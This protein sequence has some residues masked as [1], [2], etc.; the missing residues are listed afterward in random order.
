[1]VDGRPFAECF[2][3]VIDNALTADRVA[4]AMANETLTYRDL[5]QL[6][7]KRAG[8]LRRWSDDRGGRIALLQ[9][10]SFG[11][12][13]DILAGLCGGVSICV[14]SRS[15]SA[16]L[17]REKL[18]A[19][20]ARGILPGVSTYDLAHKIADGTD[21][22][23]APPVEDWPDAHDRIRP[24]CPN[25]QEEALIIFTSGSTSAPKGV[26]LSHKNI[27]VN[28]AAVSDVVPVD[29]DDHLLQV[30]PLHHTN[31]LLNQIVLPLSV[32]ARVTLLS[33]FEP[34]PF[35]S[36]LA[37]Y[38]PTYFT[39]V[40]T[41]LSRLLDY[42][43]PEAAVRNLRFIRSGAAPLLPDVQRRVEAHFGRE[44]VVS[45]GQ[46]ETTCTNTANPPGSRKI[47]SVGKV[48]SSRDAAILEPGSTAPV[49]PGATGEVCFRGACVAI[50]VIGE[51][52]LDP[53]AWFRTGDCG[54]FD[55]DGYLFL[56]GRLKD[57]I[58]KG[59][60]NLSPRQIEDVLLSQDD[61]S[62]AAVFGVP[63]DDLGEVPVAC[64][65]PA[66]EMPLDINRLNEG[67]AEKLS[68]AHMLRGIYEFNRLIETEIGKPDLRAM[69]DYVAGLETRRQ[70]AGLTV[71]CDDY[72]PIRYMDR[73]RHYYETLG[74]GAPYIWARNDE[75]PFALLQMPL[76]EASVAIITTAAPYRE[77][78]GD[79]GP[80]APYNAQ[81]KFYEVYG[82]ATDEIPDLRI[83]HVAIDR[84]NT[85]A[86]DPNAFFPLA[87]LY[88]AANA[89][90]IRR[91]APNFYGLPT[92][93]SQR[94]TRE[95][96][97][98]VLL[99]RCRADGVDAALFVPNCPVCHQSSTLAARR[100]EEEGLPTVIMG[101]A[102]DI[103]QSAGAPRF[104]F[105]D[106]PL[107]NSAGRPYDPESQRIVLGAAL[108]ILRDATAP[109]KTAQ[110]PLKW[111][112]RAGWK[113][114]Y[115]NPDQLSVEEI[116]SRKAAFEAANA[117]AKTLRERTGS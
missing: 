100:L 64:I 80:G 9:P 1:M 70:A 62:A 75:I 29:H 19:V 11:L 4:L 53:S 51:A 73:T 3:E 109:G 79:Q 43:I 77:G 66:G 37:E 27:A 52:P 5:G 17:S 49:A 63:D 22:V 84:D 110:T 96:D 20:D 56:T 15:D 108:R 38:Q 92:N 86:D 32:G 68:P 48:L 83:S 2:W 39:A 89:G 78:A 35:I 28:T 99:E 59:G 7:A 60:A 41:M 42:E 112:G 44:V 116:K 12:C 115:A 26:S 105:S 98:A 8:Q 72:E 57:I 13:V 111:Y 58:I 31:G 50:G 76:S 103:V 93:R 74:F 82:A 45:Y 40:P 23:V 107:G 71:R 95:V 55:E 21:M 102:R 54:Y 18:I 97:A 113:A 91:V 6:V 34:G 16:W 88:E 46:T 114:F 67:I 90:Q 85:Q 33:R 94:T 36:A 101:C 65:E 106:F 61:V 10:R 24:V 104:V 47:G 30:M 69:A 14:L 87:R 117:I 81:A 25:P